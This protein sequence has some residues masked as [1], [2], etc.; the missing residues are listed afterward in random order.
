MQY[1]GK[2]RVDLRYQVRYTCIDLR[3]SAAGVGAGFPLL[4]R[5][6]EWSCCI[7]ARPPLVTHSAAAASQLKEIREQAASTGDV[8]SELRAIVAG[9]SKD[10]ES[11]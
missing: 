1:S 11:D 10:V 4:Q 8:L 5:C 9:L 6:V 3:Y 7:S 2:I